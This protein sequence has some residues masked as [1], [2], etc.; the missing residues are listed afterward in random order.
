M[1]TAPD[2]K[3]TICWALFRVAYE[4][5]FEYYDPEDLSERFRTL[6][7]GW[8]W[9]TGLDQLE[10]G[11]RRRG[12]HVGCTHRWQSFGV[13]LLIDINEP[14]EDGLVDHPDHPVFN[15]LVAKA[16]ALWAAENPEQPEVVTAITNEEFDNELARL[17][18]ELTGAQLLHI[19]GVYE[20]LSEHFNNT[21][22]KNLRGGDE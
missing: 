1:K 3:N 14:A 7:E 9:F 21:I 4:A 11:F 13:H 19:P 2:F 6:E 5:G 10:H 12:P 16:E 8:E 20:A 22:L 15:E 18:G 17:A